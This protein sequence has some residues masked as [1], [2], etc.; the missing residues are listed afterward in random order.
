MP[1]RTFPLREGVTT[2]DVNRVIRKAID[3]GLDEFK[4]FSS[5]IG[6]PVRDEKVTTRKGTRRYVH[7][8]HTGLRD[9]LV[10]TYEPG[11]GVITVIFPAGY[12]SWGQAD[13]YSRMRVRMYDLIVHHADIRDKSKPE[14]KRH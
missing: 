4:T 12:K 13:F 2:A 7:G 9:T 10:A 6:R 3:Q 8:M 14:V 5:V 1:D 11:S